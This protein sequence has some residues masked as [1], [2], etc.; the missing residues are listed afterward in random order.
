MT[1]AIGL[2]GG[3]F[4]P[5]HFAHLR[6]AVEALDRLPLESI[7]WIPSG[8]PGH[9]AAP[10]GSV[11]HR[12]AML[13]LAIGDEPRF[14]LDETDARSPLPTFTVNTLTRLRAELGG[15]VPL[16]LIIGADQ[17]FAL[18][19]WRDWRN[20]FDLTHI[21]VAQRPRFKVRVRSLGDEL[22]LAYAQRSSQAASLADAPHGRIVTFNMT[23][24]DIS[25]SVIRDSIAAGHTP[26]HLLPDAVLDYIASHRL[27]ST[28]ETGAR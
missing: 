6:L 27:Y 23:P 26:R 8:Q 3:T 11:E 20:L 4:D 22:A 21:A 7:R 17:L 16:V 10:E 9:R 18:D 19:T 5:V 28:K 15:D 1:A 13:R 25:A 14:R 24:L 12:L 2:L